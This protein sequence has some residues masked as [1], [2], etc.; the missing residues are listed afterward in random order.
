[1]AGASG[2]IRAGRAFVELFVEN[3]KFYKALDQASAR[4]KATGGMWTKIGAGMGVAGAA[5]GAPMLKALGDAAARGS[6]IQTLADRFGLATQ[7]VSALA[8]AFESSGA[9]FDEFSGSLDGLGAKLASAADGNDELF[10]RLNLNARALIDLP[11]DQQLEHIADAFAKITNPIDRANI[12]QELFGASGHKLLPVLQK[13]AAGIR[14]LKKEAGE[15]GHVLDPETAKRGQDTMKGLNATWLAFKSVLLE[16][17]S[18]LLPTTEEIREFVATARRVA[19][20]IRDWVKE[21]KSVIVTVALVAAGLVAGGAALAA[22]G[23]IASGAGAAIGA[24]VLVLKAVAATVFLLLNPV[25]LAVAA[26]VLLGSQTEAAGHVLDHFRELLGGVKEVAIETF[27]GI[28]AA[29]K[30]GDLEGAMKIAG[31]GI[32]AIWAEVMLSLRKGWNDFVKW[33]VGFLK[34]NPWVLPAIGAAIGFAVGGPGGALAGAAAGGLG[35][36][37]IHEF[38]DEIVN[39]LSIDLTDATRKV[40]EAR[41]ELKALVAKA[42]EPGAGGPGA[43]GDGKGEY[44]PGGPRVEQP[45]P[46]YGAVKGVFSGPISQQLAY[47]DQLQK[48][49]LDELKGIKGAALGIIAAI[50]NMPV[51]AFKQ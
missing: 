23:A 32:T 29:L 38:G 50:Q 28:A 45:P 10:R 33:M 20:G 42:K 17:G 37:A 44:V 2:A 35:A 14:D 12:S 21:N 30:K 49:Q 4:L 9:S 8:Y 46:L 3:N 19:A 48:R 26:I 40:K 5:V 15:L 25:G 27:S 6:D 18:A 34:N 51:A 41:A 22:F 16:V 1:M 13:G 39:G 11:L 7:S 47:G 43:A 24:V 31:A 36:L